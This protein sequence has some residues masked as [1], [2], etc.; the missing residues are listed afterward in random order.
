MNYSEH[1]CMV[2][3]D[4]FTPTGKWKYTESVRWIGW[5][6]PLIHDA[7]KESL[8]E[9]FKDFPNRLSDLDAVCLEPYHRYSHPVMLKAGSWL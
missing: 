9:H 4:F 1:A 7:F 5:D 8:R 3:V 6:T 2:R